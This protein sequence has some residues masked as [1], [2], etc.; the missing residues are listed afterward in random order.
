[1]VNR[2]VVKRNTPV[3]GHSIDYYSSAKFKLRFKIFERNIYLYTKISK[4]GTR[5]LFIRDSL[6]DIM[7]E[8]MRIESI[9]W[10]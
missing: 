7:D 8:V 6:E 2:N 9:S 5:L 3:I 4:K 1:M 10:Q